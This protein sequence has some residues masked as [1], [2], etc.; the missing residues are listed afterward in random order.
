MDDAQPP[1]SDGPDHEMVPLTT[2]GEAALDTAAALSGM[3]PVLG[4]PISNVLSGL[5]QDQRMGRVN[6]VLQ[7]LS[8]QLKEL[9]QESEQYVKTEDFQDLVEETLRRVYRERNEEK[10]RIYRDFLIGAIQSPGEPYDEQMR[11]LRA[12]EQI[13]PD[14]IRVLRALMQET[15]PETNVLMGSPGQTLERRLPEMPT[16]RIADL[17]SQL[18]DLR[19]TNLGTLNVMMTGRGAEDLRSTIT[20]F[21]K[22]FV[23]FLRS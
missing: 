8:N 2:T 6:E 17:V 19:I 3:I 11:F 7:G 14:H 10:R 5:A 18:N 21:G 22:R 12:L 23:D 9:S 1:D 16:E 13:Q 20:V 4:G 15:D